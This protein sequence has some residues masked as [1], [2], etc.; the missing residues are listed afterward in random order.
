MLFST[1]SWN[2]PIKVGQGIAMKHVVSYEGDQ[3]SL[4]NAHNWNVPT[5]TEITW[6]LS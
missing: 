4:S 2:V 5:N 3:F 1:L 6:T